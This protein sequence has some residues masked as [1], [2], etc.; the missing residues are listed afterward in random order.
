MNFRLDSTGDLIFA[1]GELQMVSGPEEIAQAARV[2]LGT[3]LDEWFLDPDAGTSYDVLLQKQP[4][5]EAIRETVYSALEQ[6]E[7]IQKV[8]SID[9]RFDKE[10]RMLHIFF[11]AT[12]VNG[13]KV[14]SEVSLDA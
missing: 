14:E 8:D 4:N 6:V 12:A 13:E 1:D 5:E 9:I 2:V 11:T 7:Q 10:N 3:N